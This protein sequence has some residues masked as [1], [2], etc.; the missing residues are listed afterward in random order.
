MPDTD[1]A[2]KMTPSEVAEVFG[3]STDTVA[4]WAD[5]GRLP[6]TRTLGGHRRFLREDVEALADQ[7][8]E[9]RAAS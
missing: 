6:C 7:A 2:R 5:A 9:P 4:A 8:F 1:S 3:V